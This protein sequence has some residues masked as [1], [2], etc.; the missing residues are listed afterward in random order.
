M[1]VNKNDAE[2]KPIFCTYKILHT[3]VTDLEGSKSTLMKTAR[4]MGRLDRR[5]RFWFSFSLLVFGLGYFNGLSGQFEG[6]ILS[7]IAG[8]IMLSAATAYC[9]LCHLF[10]L[11]TFDAEEIETYGHPYEGRGYGRDQ[12]FRTYP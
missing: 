3:L 1:I 11:H 7:S 10:N 12:D 9:P 4:N 2:I 6:V 8:M 5:I